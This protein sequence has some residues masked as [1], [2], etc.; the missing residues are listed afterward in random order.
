MLDELVDVANAERPMW[1]PDGQAVDGD[2]HHEARRYL[3]EMDRV[4][5]EALIAG[6]DLEPGRIAMQSLH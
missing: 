4:V 6:E 2:F 5:I 1:H 3:F